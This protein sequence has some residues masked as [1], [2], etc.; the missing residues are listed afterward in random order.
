MAQLYNECFKNIADI[1]LTDKEKKQVKMILRRCKIGND[2]LMQVA[3]SCIYQIIKPQFLKDNYSLQN[4]KIPVSK[5]CSKIHNSK[6]TFVIQ[7][8]F[9]KYLNDISI[10]DILDALRNETNIHDS[11]VIKTIKF[12]LYHSKW[13]QTKLGKLLLNI[14]LSKFD[15]WIFNNTDKISKNFQADFS[16]HKN[17]YVNW[18]YSR[19]RK[20][21]CKYY[22]YNYE[23]IILTN[24]RVEQLYIINLIQEFNHIDIKTNY[25]Q[26]DF[27]GFHIIKRKEHGKDKIG[28]TPTNVSEINQMI[29]QTQW[30]TPKD[31]YQSMQIVLNFFR[32]YDICN[33]LS[34]YL[35]KLGLRIMKIARRKNSILKK[36][37]NKVQYEYTY[38]NQ[39]YRIDIYEL[40]K[41][42]RVSYKEYIINS[43]W[44]D[45]LDKLNPLTQFYHGHQ[46]YKY[47]LWIKQKGKDLIT[48]Q[49][50]NPKS[51]HIHH[52][53]GNHNDNN[54]TNLLLT[55]KRIHQLIHNDEVTD[56]KILKQY[57]LKCKNN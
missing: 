14:Y 33:N 56:N 44:L 53:N 36:I 30:K 19:N 39:L 34:F 28:I 5:I 13:Q 15:K 11:K 20:V 42:L 57:R 31:I 54:F 47:S 46:L 52:I 35:N 18:L 2:K 50:L 22:R 38:K 12:L 43:S 55:S 37:P 6:Q 8:D 29:N 32:E 16:R 23:A 51:L 1:L 41:T 7:L 27:L 17:N 25:N 10:D 49:W 3:E 4:K 26:L 9:T 45:Q 40:R 48:K 21:A 24:T